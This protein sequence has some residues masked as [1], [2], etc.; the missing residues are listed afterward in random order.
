LDKK[1]EIM[2]LSDSERE[3][4]TN[5]NKALASLRRDEESKWAQRAKIKHIQEGGNNTRYFHLVANGK[6]RRQKIFQLEQE[7][8]T[9]IDQENIKKYISD[10]YKTLFGTPADSNISLVENLNNDIPQLLP[11]ENSILVAD[12]SESEVLEAIEHME[13]K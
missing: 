13:K 9:I 11:E 2:L 4:L 5:A 6:H 7:E 8:G 10:Y 12:F 3:A 1:A